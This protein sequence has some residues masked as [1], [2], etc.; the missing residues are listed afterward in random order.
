MHRTCPSGFSMMLALVMLALVLAGS[1]PAPGAEAE[2]LAIRFGA[3]IDGLGKV[4]RDAVVV[5]AKGRIEAVTPGGKG[6]PSGAKMIDL[7]RYTGLPGL[8][9]A[10]T[11]MTFYWDRTDPAKPFAQ[12]LGD[13]LPA[14][15]VFLAQENARRCL[16]SGVTTV[17]DLGSNEYAD[18]AM[19]DLINKGAMI[20]PRM[21]VAGHGLHITYAS[22]RPTSEPPF[23][24][25]A[26]GSAAVMRVVRQEVFGAG[27]DVVKMFASTGTGSDVS[28]HQTF[29]FEEIKAAVD[30]AHALGVK[31][32]VHSYGP[33]GARDAVR[34]GA[35]SIEH[36]TGLDDET[37][38][39]MVKKRVFYVPT[40]DHNRYYAD[41]A[42]LF[43]YDVAAVTGLRAF[44]ERNLETAR[45]AH[46]A[47]VRFAMGSDALFSMFG[48][49][50]RELEWFVKAGMTPQEALA[51]ATRNAALLLGKEDELGAVAPG[52]YADLVAVDGDPLSDIKVVINNVKWVMKGGAV[53]V[54]KTQ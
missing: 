30:A 48:E 52:H 23:A 39:E 31:I 2:K 25:M 40:I 41:N 36:A 12:V 47:G 18:I 11:H 32:A 17:R 43:G 8:I 13:H 42:A 20:G 9:D 53:V 51:T 15:T 28:S 4:H 45:R 35:D 44:I 22:A 27:T 37:I 33:E 26:D 46:K 14:V 38:A 50:T 54:D 6:V 34:A 19:R 49:N 10:H 29:T 3:L 7:R 1:S 16:E 5:V 24:G 21:F